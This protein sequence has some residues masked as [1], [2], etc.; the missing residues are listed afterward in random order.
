MR[1]WKAVNTWHH[2]PSQEIKPYSTTSKK[3]YPEANTLGNED[4]QN[5]II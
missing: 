3:K 4:N 2:Q 1:K 5:E